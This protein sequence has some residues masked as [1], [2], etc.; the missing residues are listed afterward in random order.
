MECMS[1]TE[2]DKNLQRTQDK[3][4]A[5]SSTR[6]STFSLLLRFTHVSFALLRRLLCVMAPKMPRKHLKPSLIRRSTS[7]QSS[8]SSY[9]SLLSCCVFL[10]RH[11][12]DLLRFFVSL[13]LELSNYYQTF[14]NSIRSV[15]D[16]SQFN[17]V[18]NYS[19]IYSSSW[20]IIQLLTDGIERIL[21]CVAV[22]FVRP[23]PIPFSLQPLSMRLSLSLIFLFSL[24][25]FLF[26]IY[27]WLGSPVAPYYQATWVYS[28]EIL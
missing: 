3:A 22:V 17:S 23:P 20:I 1:T 4:C 27:K 15:L 14:V 13:A 9:N 25:N 6:A 12:Y 7:H 2:Y 18:L 26:L 16:S 11:L 28:I 21:V 24:L 8:A 5:Y 10:M 19:F